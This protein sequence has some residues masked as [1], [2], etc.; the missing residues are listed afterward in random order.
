MKDHVLIYFVCVC[1]LS[2][3]CESK[4]FFISPSL[5][6]FVYKNFDIDA[7]DHCEFLFDENE[8]K[9]RDIKAQIYHDLLQT[10]KMY[11]ITTLVNSNYSYHPNISSER[12]ETV[13]FPTLYYISITATES[14]KVTKFLQRQSNISLANDIWLVVIDKETHSRGRSDVQLFKNVENLIPNLELDSQVLIILPTILNS[15]IF[16]LYETY[17]VML[18]FRKSLSTRYFLK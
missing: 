5:M 1:I 4:K 18:D 15:D 17:K 12:K 2:L 9:S 8:E 11:N 14:T 10:L 16:M 3:S 6:H 7:V 13:R